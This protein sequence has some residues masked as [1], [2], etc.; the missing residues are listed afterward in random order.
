[1]AAL[2]DKK[3]TPAFTAGKSSVRNSGRNPLYQQF[4]E[5]EDLFE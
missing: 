2:I 1:M 4:D 5:P 3:K